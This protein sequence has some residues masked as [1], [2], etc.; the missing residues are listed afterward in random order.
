MN[1]NFFPYML[2]TF[3][4]LLILILGL[5]LIRTF[6][7]EPARVNG[8]SME[9]TYFDNDIFFV[10]KFSLLLHAPQH[11]ELVQIYEHEQSK[12]LI[13]RIIGLPGEQII[14]KQNSV[15]IV[16][17]NGQE[18]KLNEPYLANGIIT[19]PEEGGNAIYPILR[20]HE[21][22]VL[23]DNRPQ[24]IDS[25]YYGAVHRSDIIGSALTFF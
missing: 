8:R 24:S 7:I 5:I 25:R 15:F 10:N 12:F 17:H 21:Y 16:D 6:I 23:G 18:T 19:K 4:I 22:F 20:P 3:K 13:K 2:K 1:E 14:I 9:P 11:G